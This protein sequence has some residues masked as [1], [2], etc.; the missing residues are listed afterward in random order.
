MAREIQILVYNRFNDRGST[1]KILKER[2]E[3]NAEDIVIGELLPGWKWK[4][5]EEDAPRVKYYD[6]ES[7]ELDFEGKTFAA[8]VAGTETELFN[9][10]R[11]DNVNV[12]ES[13]VITLRL[14]GLTALGQ[15]PSWS[16]L[17]RRAS[18]NALIVNALT[19]IE[20][21][22]TAKIWYMRI[23]SIYNNLFLLMPETVRILE[24]E[25]G[26]DNPYAM[27]GL[28][29]YYLC[30]Q[31]D[32][33]STGKAMGLFDR[34]WKKGLDEAA[35]ALSMAYDCGDAGVVDR[36]KAK[37]LLHKALENS[38]EFAAK[39]QIHKMIYGLAGIGKN[40]QKAMQICIDLVD[41]QTAELG[42]ENVNPLWYFYSGS[43][44]R[45]ISGCTEGG[46]EFQM[47]ADAGLIMAWADLAIARS[48]D[49]NEKMT[50]KNAFLSWIR[51]GADLRD[52]FC[53]YFLAMSKVEDY[54]DMPKYKQLMAARQVVID[55]EAA[56]EAGSGEAAEALGDIFYYGQYGIDEN[57]EMAF[58]Y[59]AKGALYNSATCY[60]K[61]FDM[62][63]GHF[64]DKPLAFRDLIALHGARAGSRK[65]M[66][67]TVIAHTYGRMEEYSKEIEQLY[68]PVF[69]DEDYPD[70]DGRFDADA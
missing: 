44:K 53:M 59:Y 2:I 29:R 27:F 64:V 14:T 26:L 3:V 40:P 42:R 65:L 24:R 8:R 12:N 10:M 63:N 55:L 13:L 25:A 39:H 28:G 18:F 43:A 62:I 58:S 67:E 48:H 31:R 51:R 70:D 21:D 34:A 69:D 5:T 17:F 66:N 36:R 54:D 52:N 23:L 32:D 46:D 38:C 61:M 16:E 1:N 19:R 50:D 68:A 11:E 35:V 7:I 30:T 47:A 37:M 20:Q 49:R 15:L 56:Y 41:R 45:A 9:A 6:G 22:M 60:E 57:N 33:N 4:S